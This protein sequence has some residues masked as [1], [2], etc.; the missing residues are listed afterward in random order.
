MPL[1]II[2]VLE[3]R[4]HLDYCAFNTSMEINI[5]EISFA[6]F[7]ADMV[8]FA[9]RACVS[10]H[11]D[12]YIGYRCADILHAHTWLSADRNSGSIVP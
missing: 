6:Y 3:I 4:S 2:W 5:I 7:L 12:C 9:V 11:A 10:V 8:H 1:C